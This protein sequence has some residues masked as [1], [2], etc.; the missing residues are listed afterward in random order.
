MQVGKFPP[1]SSS[2]PIGSPQLRPVSK[3]QRGG[4]NG[5]PTFYLPPPPAFPCSRPPPAPPSPISLSRAIGKPGPSAASGYAAGCGAAII[6]QPGR[7]TTVWAVVT[8][9]LFR[10]PASRDEIAD[11][12]DAGVSRMGG[13]G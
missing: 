10:G 12:A 11:D 1:I 3:R 7:L 6:R 4:K 2:N 9:R 13:V 5:P 8:S